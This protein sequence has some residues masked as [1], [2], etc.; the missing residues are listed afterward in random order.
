MVTWGCEW[1]WC[2]PKTSGKGG[3]LGGV[4]P[5][6][7]GDTWHRVYSHCP[8]PGRRA[9]AQDVGL[10]WTWNLPTWASGSAP[11]TGCV[12]P[13]LLSMPLRKGL[14][15]VSRKDPLCP[16]TWF[17]CWPG[18]QSSSGACTEEPTCTGHRESGPFCPSAAPALKIKCGPV[19]PA[20]RKDGSLYI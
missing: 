5:C 20:R 14:L 4:S 1:G 18:G 15:P 12:S 10:T 9:S 19:N 3:S 17:P 2:W 13:L 7:P 6:H 8:G 16:V 11:S